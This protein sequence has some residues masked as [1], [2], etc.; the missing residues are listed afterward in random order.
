MSSWSPCPREIAANK[1]KISTANST[2]CKVAGPAYLKRRIKLLVM[3]Q[4]LMLGNLQ[5]Q[6][7]FRARASACACIDRRT[8]EANSHSMSQRTSSGRPTSTSEQQHLCCS[9]VPV[10]RP[11]EVRCGM[12]SRF[13]SLIISLYV[14]L[15]CL[16][17]RTF[18]ESR[19]RVPHSA[20]KALSSK[21]LSVTEQGAE[22]GQVLDL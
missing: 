11:D 2:I 14:V 1:L 12:L 3:P 7:R 22:C 21:C 15:A 17:S 20:L 9:L 13:T 4:D 19:V 10:G 5:Q 16:D 18:P 8:A 6:L